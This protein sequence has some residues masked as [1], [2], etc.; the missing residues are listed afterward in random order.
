MMLFTTILL[1]LMTGFWLVIL[2]LL[3]KYPEA[4]QEE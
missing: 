3:L 4:F 1:A 2:F